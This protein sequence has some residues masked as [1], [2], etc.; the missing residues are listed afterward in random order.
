[1]GH[2]APGKAIRGKPGNWPEQQPGQHLEHDRPGNP[3]ARPGQL[4]YEDDQRHGVERVAGARDRVGQEQAP[5]LWTGWQ[6]VQHATSVPG[7]QGDV[8]NR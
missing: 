4:K 1:V 6:Q 7:I 3:E 5:E 2:S 8:L